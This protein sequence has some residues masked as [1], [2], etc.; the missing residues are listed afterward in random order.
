MPRKKVFIGREDID[1]VLAGDV[2]KVGQSCTG[3]YEYAFEAFLFQLFHAERLADD[4]VLDEFYSHFGKVVNFHI[5][6]F[7]GQAELRN[8]I[9]QYTTN[10]VQCFENSHVIAILRHISGK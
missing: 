1:G 6:H 3:S 7:V 9:F 4:T 10:L 8:A 5:H 2:H